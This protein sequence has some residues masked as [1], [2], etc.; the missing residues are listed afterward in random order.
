MC[1]SLLILV[2][3]LFL[4]WVL[5]LNEVPARVIF[6]PQNF[7]SYFMQ[8]APRGFMAGRHLTPLDPWAWPGI[9]MSAQ[10]VQETENGVCHSLGNQGGCRHLQKI[11]IYLQKLH[12]GRYLPSVSHF[13]YL[14]PECL[15]LFRLVCVVAGGF[16]LCVIS[17]VSGATDFDIIL[18][19][20]V[21]LMLML[22]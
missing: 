1:F 20:V 9:K 8:M 5:G 6:F 10:I 13:W 16:W 14:A 18:I 4:S 22:V 7:H 12:L 15:L 3:K 21:V 11:W 17:A 19:N 2:Q